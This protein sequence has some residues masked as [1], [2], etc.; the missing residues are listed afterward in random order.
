[1][2]PPLEERSGKKNFSTTPLLSSS[3]TS[4]QLA[5]YRHST[6]HV[7]IHGTTGLLTTRN[8]PEN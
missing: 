2:P 8:T 4:P 5:L 3:K 7:S 1:V 6:L